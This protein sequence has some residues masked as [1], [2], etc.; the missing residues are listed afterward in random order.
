MEQ[1]AHFAADIIPKEIVAVPECLEIVRNDVSLPLVVLD[2]LVIVRNDV[3]LTLVVLDSLMIIRN[4]VHL[5]LIILDSL[6]IIWG[7]GKLKN[8][9][10]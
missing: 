5:T 6:K 7:Q 4:D 2:S 3:H 9:E 8:D 10:K 1:P